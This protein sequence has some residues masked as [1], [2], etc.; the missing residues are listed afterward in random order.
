MIGRQADTA[1]SFST[2]RET[3]LAETLSYRDGTWTWQGE[4]ARCTG[5]FSEDGKT[6][7]ARHERSDDGKHWEP[8]MTVKLR[9]D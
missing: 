8:W 7:T 5:V 6:L 4:H 2:A 3:S 1:R 9:I